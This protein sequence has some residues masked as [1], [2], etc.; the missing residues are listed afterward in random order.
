MEFSCHLSLKIFVVF[1]CTCVR[2]FKCMPLVFKYPEARRGVGYPG[3][4]VTVVVT[5]HTGVLGTELR[6]E[7][8]E[9]LLT[10]EPSL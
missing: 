5:H 3:T 4:G 9:V 6:V 10:A 8:Q 1:V 2:L 7:E